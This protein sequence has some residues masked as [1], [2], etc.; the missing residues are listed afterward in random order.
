M[1]KLKIWSALKQRL[2]QFAGLLL[3]MVMAVSMFASCEQNIPNNIVNAG[4]IALSASKTTIEL[5]QKNIKNSAVDFTWTT[6][7]N[8][9][10]GASISYLLQIDKKGNRF[11]TSINKDMG[12]GIYIN[13]QN[14]GTLND[15]LLRR[16]GATPGS[17]IE[18]EARVIATVYSSPLVKDTSAVITIS[19][20]PYQPVSKTL[21]II[22]DASPKGWNADNALVLT[23]QSDPTIF[24][25]QGA[26]TAG[27]FKFITTKGQLLPSYN[28]GADNAKIVYRT[29]NVQADT[30]FSITSAGVYKVVV[31]LLDLSI[32]FGKIDMPAYNDIYMVGS[33]APNGWDIAN[34]TKMT[35]SSSNP[36]IFTYRGVLNAGEFKFPV[37]RNTDWAQDM[38]M[39]LDDTHMY[40]HQG[41]SAG[42]DKWSI[43]KKGY[44]TITLNLSDNSISIYREKLYMVGS[45]TSIGWSIGS[46][47]QLTEDATNGC[48]F[49][50]SGPM[51]VG[52]FKLPVNRDSSWGQDMYMKVDDTHMYRHIGGEADDNKWTIAS[53]GNYVIT[54]NIETLSFSFVKQ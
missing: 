45:A 36:F 12:K 25:Y 53:D 14:I 21:Y 23:P 33:A 24:V 47:L 3:V 27:S 28:K 13:S 4:K 11:S 44:Y 43:A 30:Q 54:A 34:A 35:Q 1:K 46:A 32:S 17:A 51:V 18:L 22:G 39:K 2:Q 42:D 50:Y 19:V 15:S 38:F 41:G 5:N 9:G 37:N 20:K 40:L 26:L 31:N 52:E 7:V 16:W 6:G 8:H 48:I 29:T 10:T 49:T